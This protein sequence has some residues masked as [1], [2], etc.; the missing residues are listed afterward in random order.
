MTVNNI[1]QYGFLQSGWNR[2]EVITNGENQTIYQG[3][4]SRQNNAPNE[5]VWCIKRVSI[6]QSGNI[7]TIVE[8]FADGDM[9]YDNIWANRASLTYKYL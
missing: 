7:Q 5:A 8:E 4:S 6:T 1:E 3:K 9:K 2:T